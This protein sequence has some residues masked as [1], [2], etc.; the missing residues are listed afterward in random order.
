MADLVS[1]ALITYLVEIP[2]EGSSSFKNA[3]GDQRGGENVFARVCKITSLWMKLGETQSFVS[4][5][6]AHV[7]KHKHRDVL[8]IN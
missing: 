8:Y 3:A 5:T 7:Q 1:A 6:S 4:V 2:A